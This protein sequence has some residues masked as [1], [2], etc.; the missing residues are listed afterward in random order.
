MC[1]CVISHRV[2]TVFVLFVCISYVPVFVVY[3]ATSDRFLSVY[4]LVTGIYVDVCSVQDL[5]RRPTLL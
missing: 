2:C 3:V 4:C 1:E 5:I